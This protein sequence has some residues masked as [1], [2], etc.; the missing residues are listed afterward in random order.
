MVDLECRETLCRKRRIDVALFH[1]PPKKLRISL[2]KRPPLPRALQPLLLPLSLAAEP[3]ALQSRSSLYFRRRA[4]VDAKF[5]TRL[6]FPVTVLAAGDGEGNSPNDNVVGAES[7]AV[8]DSR[9]L[10]SRMVAKDTKHAARVAGKTLPSWYANDLRHVFVATLNVLLSSGGRP[11]HVNTAL[12]ALEF[13]DFIFLTAPM[14]LYR[15]DALASALFTASKINEVDPLTLTEIREIFQPTRLS[16]RAV[17]TFESQ[18]LAKFEW[19]INIPTLADFLCFQAL[20][21]YADPTITDRAEHCARHVIT[22]PQKF[23]GFRK[24][25]LAAACLVVARESVGV[26]PACPPD[27]VA[28]LALGG[29]DAALSSLVQCVDVLRAE[30]GAF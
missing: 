19:E 28:V 23:A 18:I 9:D 21:V 11:I 17:F 6:L 30:V 14:T 7:V 25:Q 4:I 24:Q 10:Y 3:N 12:L 26:L 1:E 29:D 8:F 13:A 27:L 22:K 5:R 15:D 16:K 20:F 2:A